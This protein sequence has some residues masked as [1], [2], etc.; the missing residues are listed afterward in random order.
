MTHPTFTTTGRR[1][2]RDIPPMRLYE[3]AKRLGTWN[4]GDIDF[5]QDKA[6]WKRSFSNV[7][8]APR[9]KTF[10]GWQARNR[11]LGGTAAATK[12]RP[13]GRFLVRRKEEDMRGR[14]RLLTLHFLA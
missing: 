7:P 9:W 5:S 1:L 12:K 4:P 13:G 8:A 10:T 11:A 14:I 6:D 2:Q 3:K